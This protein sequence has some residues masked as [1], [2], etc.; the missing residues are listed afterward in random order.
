MS[1][2]EGDGDGRRLIFAT[3][4][5][6]KVAELTDLLRNTAWHVER[7]PDDI[8]EYEE[9]GATFAANARGKALHAAA[10]LAVPVLADDSGLEIDALDGEPGVRSARYVDP[11]MSPTQRNDAVLEMLRDVPQQQRGARFVCH[12]V[13]AHGDVVAHETTGTCE[14]RITFAPRGDGGFGYDPIFEIPSLGA[15]FAEISRAE[16]SARS[17]R[18]RAVRAMVEFLRSWAPR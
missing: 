17:H 1:P 14:G 5:E 9:T 18:G 6:G 16:K 4:N 11:A 2:S 7:L 12:L 15:T 3:R 10:Y 8:G 13:L